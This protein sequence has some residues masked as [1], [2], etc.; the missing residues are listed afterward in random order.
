MGP[1]LFWGQAGLGQLGGRGGDRSWRGRHGTE[2]RPRRAASAARRLCG[3]DS[4]RL[5]SAPSCALQ[6]KAVQ[7]QASEVGAAV[8]SGQ[9]MAG[10][11]VAHN[12][13]T[14]RDRGRLLG[15]L[16]TFKTENSTCRTQDFQQ[17]DFPL[18]KDNLKMWPQQAPVAQA[19]TPEQSPGHSPEPGPGLQP[20]QRGSGGWW[21][22]HAQVLSSAHPPFQ[23]PSETDP[24][25]ISSSLMRKLT[26]RLQAR[27]GTQRCVHQTRAAGCTKTWPL[28]RHQHEWGP[29]GEW[30]A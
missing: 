27:L 1:P 4:G 17:A 24:V 11:C 19:A 20:G 30:P 28:N 26:H 2:E 21:H 22:M 25:I 8:R 23:S 13:R 3:R 5:C 10:A 9:A 18:Q 15:A 12:T 6:T 29:A 14:G 16:G 7:R